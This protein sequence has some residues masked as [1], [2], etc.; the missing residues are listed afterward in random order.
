MEAHRDAI[1][2]GS[3]VLYLV[4]CM[5]IGLWAMRRTKNAH[6]FFMAG[7]EL[8]FMVT[9]MAIFSTTLSGFAFVG[10]PGLVYRMGI[11]S[12]WI[13]IASSI[14]FSLSSYMLA[15]RLR[16][17]AELCDTVSL[18]DAVAAR[19]NSE[20]S[21]ALTAVAILLGVFG[22]LATQILAMSM[23]L[24]SLLSNIFETDVSL[25]ACV[26]GSSL[27]LVFYCVTGGIIASVY[28]DIVQGFIMMVGG[29]LVF[30]AAAMA[31][32]GGPVVAMTTILQDDSEAASPWGT[33]G[34]LGCLSWYFLFVV[35]GLGQPH[36][37][38]KNM[39]LRRIEDVRHVLPA[40]MIGYFFS[41]LLW[42]AIGL[43]MRALVLRGEHPELASADLAAAEF[44]QLYA[45]PLLAGAVFAGLFA[46]IMSTADA[47][48]NIG[49]AALV[50]DLPQ[51]LGRTVHNK[52]FWARVATVV[53]AVVA[54]AFALYS[55]YQNERLVAILGAFG[56]GTFGAAL[57][58]AV[59]IG[60]NWK[61]ATALAAN[62]AIITSLIFN[63]VM[64]LADIPV[65]WGMNVGALSLV[66]SLCLFFG[67]SLAS[68]PPDLD[69][70]IEAVM[71]F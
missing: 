70:D 52:L 38:T 48:L 68:K 30:V 18:A 40:T 21:R 2:L 24:A 37:I 60:F 42:I 1:I 13:V 32:E 59:A 56:W 43:A 53:I 11:S 29:T 6:D 57:V 61:R 17:F 15:K 25:V 65:P 35:G 9:A 46:A 50:H 28:T 4:A 63:L 31:V 27:V 45:H 49:A 33:L 47:F 55:H 62:T 5:G 66:L 64:E 19:Y 34:I 26:A 69:P 51:A 16:L 10:G 39:M 20:T 44:L 22:Y 67:I 3:V 23:V 12:L 14:G 54:S 71:D 36:I 7:R 8:G 41:A 58:P